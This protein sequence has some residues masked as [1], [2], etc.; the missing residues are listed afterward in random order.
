MAKPE[1]IGLTD[2]PECHFPD[3]EV[4]NDKSGSPYRFCPDCESQYFTRGESKRAKNLMS[5][6]RKSE[7]PPGAPAASVAPVVLPKVNTTAASTPGPAPA[8]KNPWAPLIGG[9]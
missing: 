3:A 7:A 2:C 6:I 5:K 4:R 8:K 1:L 9:A